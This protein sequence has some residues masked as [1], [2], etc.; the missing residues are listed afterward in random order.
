MSASRPTL[1]AT[2]PGF[3]HINRYWDPYRQAPAVKV[4]PGECYVSNQHEYI[5]TTLGSCIAACIWDP[6]AGVGGLNHFLLAQPAAS[7]SPAAQANDS[8]LRYG[9]FAMEVLI[10]AI[11]KHG[12]RRERLLVKIA[13]GGAVLNGASDIGASNIAFTRHY[14]QTEKL[15]LQG[16]HVGGDLPRKVCFHPQTGQAQV[17]SLVTTR[18]DTVAAR[19]RLYVEILGKAVASGGVE[20]FRELAAAQ[21]AGKSD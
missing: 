17:K 9:L 21:E 13:G 4:L 20:L 11:L 19:E 10:N 8:A 7:F 12:G 1:P 2:L 14:L 3:E 6:V 15:P 18:N 16:E 5:L